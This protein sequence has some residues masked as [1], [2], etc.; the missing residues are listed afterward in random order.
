MRKDP[1]SGAVDKTSLQ[2]V[3]FEEELYQ[4]AIMRIIRC[5]EFGICG[6]YTTFSPPSSISNRILAAAFA[7]FVCEQKRRCMTE[8]VGVH[9]NNSFDPPF[10]RI[11]YSSLTTPLR[12]L[13]M[14]LNDFD[15]KVDHKSNW[16]MRLK[17]IH[18]LSRIHISY[19]RRTQAWPSSFCLKFARSVIRIYSYRR[20]LALPGIIR[21]FLHF[22]PTESD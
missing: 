3:S 15:S 11:T 6:D 4:V 9:L 10:L 14:N 5:F 13:D 19:G 2:Q 1:K 21:L 17:S 16:C 8:Q 12:T 7:V 22:T 18:L 20:I